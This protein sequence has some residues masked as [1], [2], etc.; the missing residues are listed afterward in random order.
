M[1]PTCPSGFRD[2]LSDG[3]ATSDGATVSTVVLSLLDGVWT[4]KKK[5]KE[6]NGREVVQSY[7]FGA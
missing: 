6:S 4:G 3:I 2:A 5:I 1:I 7:P